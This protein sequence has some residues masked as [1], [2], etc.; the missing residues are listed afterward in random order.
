MNYII[1]LAVLFVA[2]SI[3]FKIADRYNIV[4]KPN[5][6]SSHSYI[7]LRGGGIIFWIA[8]TIYSSFH[9]KE[10][11][12]F[13]VGSTLIS[14]ISF[15]DD[16][17][18]LPSNIRFT[19]HLIAVSIA[20]Y[21]IGVFDLLNTWQTIFAYLLVVGLVNAYN[22]MDGINGITGLYSL[23]ILLALIYINERLIRFSDTD[24]ILFAICASIVFLFFNYR[25]RAR[26]FAGDVGS[27]S[28]AFWISV[29]LMQLILKTN[30]P[31]WLLLLTLYGV[32]TFCTILHRIWLHQNIFKPHRLHFYQI[33]ANEYRIDHRT[34]ALGYA[35]LQALI[36]I[37]IIILYNQLSTFWLYPLCILPIIAVYNL[38]FVLINKYSSNN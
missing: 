29:L 10:Y 2:I 30:N 36:A 8:G 34:V 7:T 23:S 22:F 14:L 25:K 16:I 38:K 31:V 5:A 20:F 24:F 18:S 1:L 13:L 17:K 33:L 15:W 9:L 12:Y 28:M 37:I 35:S 26:C 21:G 3:Y 11:S 27:V 6:R 4:D 19:V 32:D